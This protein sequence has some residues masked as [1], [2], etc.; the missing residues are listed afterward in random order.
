MHHLKKYK[1]KYIKNDAQNYK[2]WKIGIEFNKKSLTSFFSKIKIS[3][4]KNKTKNKK[5]KTACNQCV[6]MRASNL[7]HSHF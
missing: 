6:I 7:A 4:F 5:N 2:G 1:T 3:K